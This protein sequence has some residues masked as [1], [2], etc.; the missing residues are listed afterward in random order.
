MEKKHKK[1]L[2]RL[3]FDD[4]Y[5]ASI[6]QLFFSYKRYNNGLIG[7]T[8]VY[9]DNAFLKDLRKEEIKMIQEHD[10]DFKSKIENCID[11]LLKQLQKK[12]FEQI[13]V[14]KQKKIDHLKGGQKGDLRQIQSGLVM[15]EIRGYPNVIRLVCQE[16]RILIL[17]SNDYKKILFYGIFHRRD[18]Y[19]FALSKLKN[20]L[21]K[22]IA[23]EFG[24][25]P[26]TAYQNKVLIAEAHRADKGIQYGRF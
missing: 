19:M 11:E 15:E 7:S 2:E 1:L 20:V 3:G 24:L 21:E 12:T 6:Y 8:M 16:H 14:T 22:P 18:G 5:K 9:Y 13:V 26:L 23:K 25:K 17:R 4:D 10:Y